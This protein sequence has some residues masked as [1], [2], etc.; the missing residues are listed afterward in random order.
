M[1]AGSFATARV[2]VVFGFLLVQLWPSGA[3]AQ[4]VAPLNDLLQEGEHGESNGL[5][6]ATN[7]VFGELAGNG[8]LLS[9]N[10]EK[11]VSNR[12]GLRLGV[13]SLYGFGTTVP[14]MINFYRGN[15]YRLE[16]GAGLVFLPSWNNDVS[17]GSAGSAL[18]TSTLGLRFQQA[19]GGII[20]RLSATPF[21]DLTTKRIRFLAGA[22]IGVAF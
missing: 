15:R 5:I 7:V 11:L 18:I 20:I 10:Y 12:L 22:S 19:D 2:I 6:S 16:T 1:R 8:I 3:G 9:M 14:L 17:F 4:K 13:G 21:Y